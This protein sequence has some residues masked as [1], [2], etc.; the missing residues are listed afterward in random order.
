MKV[1]GRVVR[2]AGMHRCRTR[3][4]NERTNEEQ[5]T[6]DGRSEAG[7]DG[8]GTESR[9]ERDSDEKRRKDGT[10]IACRELCSRAGQQRKGVLGSLMEDLWGYYISERRLLAYALHEQHAL[11]VRIYP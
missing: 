3:R 11:H 4:T 8:K 10:E 1:L 7:G 6:S 5:S 9:E 2:P